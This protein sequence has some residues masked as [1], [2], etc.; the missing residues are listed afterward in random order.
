M[1]ELIVYMKGKPKDHIV[2]SGKDLDQEEVD[3]QLATIGDGIGKSGAIR[4]PWAVLN[5]E[6]IIAVKVAP[7]RP[8]AA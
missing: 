3:G 1:P 4:L 5:G 7:D 6:D 2:R 8:S